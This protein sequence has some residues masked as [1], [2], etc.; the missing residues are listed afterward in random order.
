MDLQTFIMG[1]AKEI[2]GIASVAIVNLDGTP[3]AG[4]SFDENLDVML[5][6]AYFTEV[7]KSSRESF[8]VTNWGEFEDVLI[9]SNTH[10]I[11]M[12]MVSDSIYFGA[13]VSVRKGN[14]GLLRLK[15]KM[16]TTNILKFLR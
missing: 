11:V 10:Y 14:L 3:V 6:A 8:N 1:W 5:P 16:A 13:A 15:M 2:S 4:G 12:R 7:V 9:T